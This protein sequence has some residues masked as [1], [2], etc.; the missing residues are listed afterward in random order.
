MIALLHKDHPCP[1]F[2]VLGVVDNGR[3][4]EVQTLWGNADQR[5]LIYT[6]DKVAYRNYGYYPKEIDDALIPELQA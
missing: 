6:I 4:M 2:K 5:R 3:K 1:M